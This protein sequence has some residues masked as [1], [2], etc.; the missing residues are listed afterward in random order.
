MSGKVKLTWKSLALP[1]SLALLLAFG[2]ATAA[3]ADHA[4]WIDLTIPTWTCSYPVSVNAFGGN[5]AML[6][7][8]LSGYTTM[9]VRVDSCNP[10]GFSVNI[11]D[12]PS[13]DG[14]G[15]DKAHT[16]HDAEVQLSGSDFSAFRSEY[17]PGEVHRAVGVVQG[18]C[19]IQQFLIREDYAEFDPNINAV[20]D[21]LI[22]VPHWAL[23]DLPPSYGEYDAEDPNGMQ[24]ETLF[25]GLNRVVDMSVFPRT[26]TGVRRACVYLSTAFY[27]NPASVT[28]ACGF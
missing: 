16:R 22:Q 20:G 2:S 14:G 4:C 5:Q 27:P 11:G 19:T 12:S 10:T 8:R 6:V 23:F 17:N 24:L 3:R 7:A 9:V 25:I 26:G 15:G 1:T 18:G 28:A 13:N 21:P